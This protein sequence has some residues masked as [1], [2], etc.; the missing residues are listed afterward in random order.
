M[1]AILFF[2]RKRV[3]FQVL[4]DT[5]LSCE[6]VNFSKVSIW[7]SICFPERIFMNMILTF[8]KLLLPSTLFSN[9]FFLI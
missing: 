1:L 4:T 2:H 3:L 7:K 5:D 6:P 9:D 8:S